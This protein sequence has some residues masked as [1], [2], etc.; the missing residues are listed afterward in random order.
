MEAHTVSTA[1]IRNLSLALALLFLAG[2]ALSLRAVVRDE[3]AREITLHSRD[4]AFYLPGGTVPNPTLRLAAGE[5]VRFTLVNDEAGMQHDLA[6]EGTGVLVAALPVAAGSR[7]SARFVA[8][9]RP[10][11]YP[12]VCTMHGQMMRGTLEVTAAR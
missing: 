12:Y 1:R 5:E 2:V 6:V 4:M 9:E 11:R 7:G 8:P 10:G 3:P